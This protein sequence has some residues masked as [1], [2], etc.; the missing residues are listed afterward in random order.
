MEKKIF[1]LEKGS[2]QG[3]TF[4]TTN[5]SAKQHSW[6]VE[7]IVKETKVIGKGYYNN[8]EIDVFCG[9]NGD[10]KIFEIEANSSLTIWYD[11]EQSL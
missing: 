5:K 3:A 10:N 8:L 2:G 1:K 6:Y 4:Y 7:K 9:Y 11:N